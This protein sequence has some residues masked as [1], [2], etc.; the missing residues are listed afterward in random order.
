MKKSNRI[1]AAIIISILIFGHIMTAQAA[2]STQ[3]ND[4]TVLVDGIPVVFDQNPVHINDRVMVP[5]RFVAEAM[6]WEVRSVSPTVVE[7]AKTAKYTDGSKEYLFSCHTVTINLEREWINRSIMVG[8]GHFFDT[9]NDRKIGLTA[10]PLVMNGRTLVGV[11]DLAQCLYATVEWDGASRTVII[12]SGAIP[13]YDGQ[14]LPNRTEL[15]EEMRTYHKINGA[16]T[17]IE[18]QQTTDIQAEEKVI[19][20][21][22]VLVQTTGVI[23]AIP[24]VGSIPAKILLPGKTDVN[25]ADSYYEPYKTRIGYGCN[26]YAFGRFYEIF[27]YQIPVPYTGGATYIDEVEKANP[28]SIRAERDLYKIISGC[29]AVYCRQNNGGH[30]VFVEYVERDKNGNPVNVYFTECLNSDGSGTYKPAT[31]G[32]IKKA[33]FERFKKSSSGTKDLMGFIMPQH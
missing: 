28:T 5:V 21:M 13:Y 22:P 7:L 4:I 10:K 32:K 8:I 11:R 1:I 29:I 33:T 18:T 14:G 20:E 15:F 6:G 2:Q 9:E 3:E 12:T 25:S 19:P 27:G 23:T 30:V 17:K 16:L 26:W 24:E 31:D